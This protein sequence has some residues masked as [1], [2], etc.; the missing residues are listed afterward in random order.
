M[1]ERIDK[2]QLRNS[3]SNS[4]VPINGT[5]STL[6]NITGKNMLIAAEDASGYNVFQFWVENGHQYRT[7]RVMRVVKARECG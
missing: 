7:T 4:L 3:V 1:E 2:T 5:F 6:P